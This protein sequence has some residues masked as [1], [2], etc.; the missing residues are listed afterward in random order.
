MSRHPA[1]DH[2]SAFLDGELDE[3]EAIAVEAALE[4]DPTLREELARL[5]GVQHLLRTHGRTRAPDGFTARVLE[6]AREQTPAAAPWWRR[7]FGVPLEGVLVA[8]AAALVL[9]IAVPRSLE[10]EAPPVAAAG[11]AADVPDDRNPAQGEGLVDAN[12]DEDD[13]V[14]VAEG[15]GD[16]DGG[17]TRDGGAEIG[18]GGLGIVG[19]GSGGGG[20]GYGAGLGSKGTTGKGGTSEAPTGEKLANGTVEPVAPGPGTVQAAPVAGAAPAPVAAGGIGEE[21]TA[22]SPFSAALYSEDEE[23]L[24]ALQRLAAQHGGRI[25]DASGKLLTL[26][27]LEERETRLVVEVPGDQVAAFNRG[28]EALGARITTSGS[29]DLTTGSLV[30]FPLRVVWV[31]NAPANQQEPPPAASQR[32]TDAYEAVD[33]E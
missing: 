16:G 32:Q 10:A 19:K 13:A 12:P 24:G 25:R 31:A 5:K 8:A 29:A 18:L 4:A 3:A 22:A 6:A 14:A 11:K 2:L 28:L 21:Q 7:P 15:T 9:I 17:G 27:V 30:Q 1:H 20:A 26:G 23:I 33:P